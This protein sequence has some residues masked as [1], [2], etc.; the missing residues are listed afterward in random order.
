[1]LEWWKR[2]FSAL[3]HNLSLWNYFYVLLNLLNLVHLKLHA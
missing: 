2:L 3:K 1:M